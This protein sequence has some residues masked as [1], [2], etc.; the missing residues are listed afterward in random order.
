MAG[1]KR[2]SGKAAGRAAEKPEPKA[3]SS[4][5]EAVDHAFGVTGGPP[6]TPKGSAKLPE[7]YIGTPTSLPKKPPPA[8]QRKPTPLPHRSQESLASLP[9]KPP[10]PVTAEP[11]PSWL[12][13]SKLPATPETLPKKPQ[14]LSSSNPFAQF[15][16]GLTT[17]PTTD[18]S[19]PGNKSHSISQLTLAQIPSLGKA[20][21]NCSMTQSEEITASTSN[22]LTTNNPVVGEPAIE[23]PVI[24][25][26]S[27]AVQTPADQPSTPEM[28]KA[29]TTAACQTEVQGSDEAEASSSTKVANDQVTQAI[30]KCMSTS[31]QIRQTGIVPAADP[32]G[33]LQLIDAKLVAGE[34]TLTPPEQSLLYHLMAGMDGTYK[35]LLG[36]VATHVSNRDH[37]LTFQLALW[38][39][40]RGDYM[41]TRMLLKGRLNDMEGAEGDLM[42]LDEVDELMGC[43]IAL[44]KLEETM[45]IR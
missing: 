35:I 25:S 3:A 45:G 32:S 43:Q 12:N 20:L 9:K 1:R 36:R 14:I 19:P 21:F 8:V 34:K 22:Q 41:I 38:F 44:E 4:S 13:P 15:A 27:I 16:T 2:K 26:R 28:A 11:A 42:N 23:Q 6:L 18:A 10:T 31:N 40:R 7:N 37:R 39:Y 17:P 5:V 29:Q 24:I 30:I 33:A